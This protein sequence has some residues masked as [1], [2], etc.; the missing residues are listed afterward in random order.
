MNAKQWAVRGPGMPQKIVRSEKILTEEEV[1]KVYLKTMRFVK[2]EAT[3]RTDD[4]EVPWR[5]TPMT[6]EDIQKAGLQWCMSPSRRQNHRSLIQVNVKGE[7]IEDVL[8]LPPRKKTRTKI[9]VSVG[10]APTK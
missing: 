6:D 9:D 10:A 3:A 2:S 4:L 5:I 7:I 8:V 1:K